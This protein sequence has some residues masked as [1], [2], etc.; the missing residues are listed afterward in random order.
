MAI[1][2]LQEN[3]PDTYMVNSRDFQLISRI[4]DCVNNSVRFDIET[5]KYLSNTKFCRDSYLNILKYKLGF[6]ED[7]NE[8]ELRLILDS[9]PIILKNKGNLTAIR[10]ALNLGT[11]LF[12]IN[13]AIN[14]VKNSES[15]LLIEF[16]AS[17]ISIDT[18]L[19]SFLDAIFK[20]II[21]TGIIYS[22]EFSAPVQINS[23]ISLTSNIIADKSHD[24]DKNQGIIAVEDG[25]LKE[26][27]LHS[28]IDTTIIE[29]V[30]SEEND[31]ME[32]IEGEH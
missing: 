22:F 18:N 9:F 8:N 24:E 30:E 20:Y 28:R 6:F 23:N 16:Q 10:Q 5:L 4:Y 19:I 32:I 12:N 15:E 17:N 27:G 11:R 7:L 13:S 2:R 31:K 26:Q 14:I 21:P 29:S 3:I 1:L 25:E